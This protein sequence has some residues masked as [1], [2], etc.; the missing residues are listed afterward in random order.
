MSHDVSSLEIS[1][2][3]KVRGIVLSSFRAFVARENQPEN[4]CPRVHVPLRIKKSIFLRDG[5]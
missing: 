1:R 5:D 4:A 2:R 3:M